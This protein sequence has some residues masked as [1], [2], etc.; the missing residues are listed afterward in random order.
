MPGAPSLFT[1]LSTFSD[2]F[3]F[4]GDELHMLG[5]GIGH[6]V[7]KLLDNSTCDHYKPLHS[8]QYSFDFASHMSQKVFMGKLG[9]WI[10]QS[11]ATTT[12]VFEYSF[13]SRKGYYRALD[14]QQF[15]LYIVPTMVIPN[16]KHVEARIGLMNL[17]D[18]CSIALQKEITS[19]EIDKM[20]V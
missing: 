7:H 6:L 1:S 19:Q 8:T 9:T 15:L 12:S 4:F 10:N 2:S 20:A 18:A 3:F 5:H 13:D 16:L 14:W 17:V 11:K